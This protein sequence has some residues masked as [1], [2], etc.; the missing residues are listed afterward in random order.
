[1]TRHV[2]LDGAGPARA[3]AFF[4][5]GARHCPGNVC[6]SAC[7]ALRVAVRRGRRVMARA[8]ADAS[9]AQTLHDDFSRSKPIVRTS[10]RRVPNETAYG[11]SGCVA[12]RYAERHERAV[13]RRARHARHAR[14]GARADATRSWSS[15]RSRGGRVP[16]GGRRTG[17]PTYG[18]ASQ[19]EDTGRRRRRGVQETGKRRVR[20]MVIIQPRFRGGVRA[21]STRPCHLW[22]GDEAIARRDDHANRAALG[23]A[24]TGIADAARRRGDGNGR[25]ENARCSRKKTRKTNRD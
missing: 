22:H 4:A 25:G 24:A 2:S 3:S 17:R 19:T 23:H 14:R 10:P 16:R 1:M 11:S 12:R 7:S 15:T 21:R 18:D 6:G 13:R 20:R 9:A 5:G 8:H